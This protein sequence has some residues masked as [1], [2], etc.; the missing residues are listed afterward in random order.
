MI[1]ILL[2][3]VVVMMIVG[4]MMVVK[5]VSAA[6]SNVVK[7]ID[8]HIAKVVGINAV[9]ITLRVKVNIDHIIITMITDPF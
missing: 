8:K 4:V 2:F 3:G 6:F 5:V 9:V 1:F 7:L